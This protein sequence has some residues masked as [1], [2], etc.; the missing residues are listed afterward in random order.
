MAAQNAFATAVF[1]SLVGLAVPAAAQ[2]TWYV[3]DDNCPGPGSGSI[4]D[5]FCEIQPAID[6]STHGDEVLVLPGTYNESIDLQGKAITL[7]SSGGAEVTTIQ[8]GAVR[9]ES[10]EGHDT[11][12]DGF[13]VAGASGSG[14]YVAGSSPTVVNCTFRDTPWPGPDYGGGMTISGSP[15]V[16]NCVFINNRSYYRGGGMYIASG[17]QPRVI[18]CAFI[19]NFTGGESGG[20]GGA[21]YVGASANAFVVNCDFLDNRGDWGGAIRG[22]PTLVN[23]RFI[24]NRGYFGGEAVDTNNGQLVNC[25]FVSDSIHAAGN[26]IVANCTI[27]HNVYRGISCGSG[28]NVHVR[29]CI[30]WNNG[31]GTEPYQISGSAQVDYCC[32]QGWTGALGGVGNIGDDPL[33]VDPDGPDDEYGTEDDDL[34]L[35]PGSPCIDAGG[36]VYVPLDLADLDGDGDIYERIPR[37]LDYAPRFVDDP[38]TEDHGTGAPGYPNIVDMGAY[39]F[40]VVLAATSLLDHG[41]TELGLDLVANNIEPRAD[42]VLKVAFEL[43]GEVTSASASVSCANAV[44]G[45]SVT[46]TADGTTV[47][48]EFDPALPDRDCCEIVLTGDVAANLWVRTLRGDVNRGGSTDTTDAAQ[49][50]LRF[51]QDAAVAGAQW[52]YNTSGEVNT[53]DYSQIKLVFGATAPECP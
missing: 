30:L 32:V 35:Q 16:R 29:N 13:T 40:Q 26:A 18:G 46:T 1:L 28:S 20:G 43:A 9:C 36:N 12:V 49:I 53:T 44:Y 47:T 39:E 10:G 8:A 37:D 17:N 42:G 5:P 45:G 24:G 41:G 50:K 2:T 52:D 21:I 4:G 51:G 3:D 19:D 38:D 6:A 33:F 7:H 48:V 27:V 25:L 14:M 23:C 31:D 15:E 22:D 11:V 34:H